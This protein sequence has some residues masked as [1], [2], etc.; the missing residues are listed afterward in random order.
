MH[1]QRRLVGPQDALVGI[2]QNN[3]VG[4][5]GDDLLQLAAI[6]FRAQDVLAHRI[7]TRMATLWRIRPPGLAIVQSNL[8]GASL[9]RAAV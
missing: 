5:T 8:V 3:P 4:Q 2:E 1:G 7:S 6:G 9:L